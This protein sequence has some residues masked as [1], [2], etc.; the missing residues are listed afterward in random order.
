MAEYIMLFRYTQQGISKIKDSPQRVKDAKKLFE[1]AGA[2][3]KAFYAVLGQYDTVCVVEAPDNETI[4][5]IS[6]KV[7]SLGFVHAETLPAF[8]ENEFTTIINKV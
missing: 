8:N 6:L 3:I 7:S 2:K 4:T 5:R 1:A